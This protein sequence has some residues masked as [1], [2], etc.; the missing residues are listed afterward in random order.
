MRNVAV[1]HDYYCNVMFCFTS[2]NLTL[3][4]HRMQQ[5]CGVSVVLKRLCLFCLISSIT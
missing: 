2:V 1:S 3:N 5:L 4:V